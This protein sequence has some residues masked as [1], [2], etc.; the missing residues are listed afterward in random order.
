[1]IDVINSAVHSLGPF[2]VLTK[3]LY[4]NQVSRLRQTHRMG[5]DSLS[6]M[7]DKANPMVRVSYHYRPG[8]LL[9]KFS[10][11]GKSRMTAVSS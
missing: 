11:P 2:S 6:G 9:R 7:P 4:D 5:A 3:S 8:R 1:M 10:N